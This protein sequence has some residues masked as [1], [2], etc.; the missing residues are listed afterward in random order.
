MYI[1]PW[2]LNFLYKYRFYFIKMP[3]AFSFGTSQRGNP[4]TSN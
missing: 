1:I 4:K 2:K 3:P